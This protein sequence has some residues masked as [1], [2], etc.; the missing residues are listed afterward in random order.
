MDHLGSVEDHLNCV[1]ISI[2]NNNCNFKLLGCS[3]FQTSWWH[4]RKGNWCKRRWWGLL[5]VSCYNILSANMLPNVFHILYFRWC[6][7]YFGF[8][9]WWVI[10]WGWH[11]SWGNWFLFWMYVCMYVEYISLVLEHGV[12]LLCLHCCK[13]CLN[14]FFSF[15]VCNM[16]WN[17][18]KQKW[19]IFLIYIFLAKTL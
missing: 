3:G 12:C 11:C 8:A 1:L 6:L 19:G 10:V 17:I 5:L 14:F 16:H 13:G 7:G 9:A 18:S 4:N 2:W 15:F